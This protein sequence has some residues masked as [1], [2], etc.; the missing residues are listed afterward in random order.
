MS[1]TIFTKLLD[2]IIL[3]GIITS[4]LKY[5][6]MEKYDLNS[7]NTY[8]SLEVGIHE[9][10]ENAE[11]LKNVGWIRNNI[12]RLVKMAGIPLVV[13]LAS[14]GG[15]SG[16]KF[17]PSGVKLVDGYVM[18]KD[19]GADSGDADPKD[20]DADIDAD[21]DADIDADIDAEPD[22]EPVEEICD[23]GIDNTDNGLTDC[24]DPECDGESCGD[25]C[26]CENSRKKE[27]DCGDSIDNNGDGSTDCQNTDCDGELGPEGQICEPGGETICDDGFDNSGNGLV[28]CADPNCATA[29]NCL[30][31]VEICDN[32]IDDTGNGRIDCQDPECFYNDPICDGVEYCYDDEDNSGNGYRS[33]VDATCEDDCDQYIDENNICT[34]P[35]GWFCTMSE[36]YS[37]AP[38]YPNGRCSDEYSDDNTYCVCLNPY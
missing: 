31:P 36:D 17:D 18:P 6:I 11:G 37:D 2:K 15:T 34:D 24:E 35:V 30:E 19:G 3:F 33:C 29:P 7:E 4:T 22:A 14:L 13:A 21:V 8:E 26:E 1:V 10:A 9:Q 16:C 12:R 25:G 23:D 20:P 27:V 5:N 38:C 28:D 32:G